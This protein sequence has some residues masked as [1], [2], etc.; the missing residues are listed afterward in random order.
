MD[1][2]NE[3]YT[4]FNIKLK[5]IPL[6]WEGQEMSEIT[7]DKGM[8]NGEIQIQSLQSCIRTLKY[9][10]ASMTL[11]NIEDEEREKLN[12]KILEKVLI[13]E[14]FFINTRTNKLEALNKSQTHKVNQNFSQTNMHDQSQRN[15]NLYYNQ[16]N[17]NN[18]RNQTQTQPYKRTNSIMYD[19]QSQND[20]Y[21]FN[22]NESM[23]KIRP[24]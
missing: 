1:F 21:D 3:K 18:M 12:F 16:T 24:F 9:E 22:R 15:V 19:D 23:K 8:N 20:L 2:R 10:A 14:N 11:K 5:E 13:P 17:N 7:K 4:S 6:I